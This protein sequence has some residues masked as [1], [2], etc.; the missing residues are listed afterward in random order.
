MASCTVGCG[1]TLL[2][3]QTS[4]C[5]RVQ[6]FVT[7]FCD[8]LLV[9]RLQ[10]AIR[11][12][13]AA[14]QQCRFLDGSGIVTK[15]ILPVFGHVSSDLDPEVRAVGLEILGGI[16]QEVCRDC[17]LRCLLMFAGGQRCTLCRFIE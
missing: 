2:S 10:R 3:T 4:R 12:L 16:I 7:A 14:W 6:P 17:P 13:L 15:V 11:S 9:S 8:V 5:Q 1:S